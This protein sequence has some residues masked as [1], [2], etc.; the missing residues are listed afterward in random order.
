MKLLLV[1]IYTLFII[2][3]F[4]ANGQSH[5]ELCRR[6]SVGTVAEIRARYYPEMTN[7]E[8]DIVRK[9]AILTCMER[10]SENDGGVTSQPAASARRDTNKPASNPASEDSH[11]G[12][13]DRILGGGHQ[14]K[15]TTIRRRQQ[16]GGK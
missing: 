12:W 5:D 1:M 14:Q 4:A 11:S 6:Q 10:S 9:T 16:T 7:R 2:N 15:A 3:A 13:L 8:M